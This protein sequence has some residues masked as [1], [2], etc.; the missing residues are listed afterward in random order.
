MIR[1]IVHIEEENATA[2]VPVQ[3]PATKELLP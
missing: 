1:K 3:L 2:V